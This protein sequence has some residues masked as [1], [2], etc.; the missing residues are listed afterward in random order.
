[1]TV[2]VVIFVVV[3]AQLAFG[4]GVMSN[5]CFLRLPEEIATSKTKQPQRVTHV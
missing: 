4:D 1:M 3:A 2:V 5:E